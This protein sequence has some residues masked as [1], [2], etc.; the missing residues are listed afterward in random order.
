MSSPTGCFIGKEAVT[1]MVAVFNKIKIM[2]QNT[3]N[4]TSGSVIEKKAAT[5]LTWLQKL[6]C[7]L[8]RIIPERLYWYEAKVT[9]THFICVGDGIEAPDGRQWRVIEAKNGS[10]VIKTVLPANRT[11]ALVGTWAISYYSLSEGS[12]QPSQAVHL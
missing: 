8:F 4:V 2:R 1:V 11:P 10:L 6:V 3:F 9:A 12:S 5:H 7:K